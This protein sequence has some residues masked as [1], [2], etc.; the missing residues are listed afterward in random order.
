MTRRDFLAA[1]ALAGVADTGAQRVHVTV[2]ANR[3]LG[4]IPVD[5]LGLGYE[6][7]SVSTHGLL[8]ATNRAYVQLMRT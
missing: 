4:V 5:F 2:D 6:I 3:K 7:S 8:S 1:A